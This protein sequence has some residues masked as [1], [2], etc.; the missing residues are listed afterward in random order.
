MAL[1]YVLAKPQVRSQLICSRINARLGGVTSRVDPKNSGLGD[2]IM[3]IGM[4]YQ[5][6]STVGIRFTVRDRMRCDSSG[7]RGSEA[8]NSQLGCLN[9]HRCDKICV[10][11]LSSAADQTGGYRRFGF[12]FLC[13]SLLCLLSCT[14]LMSLQRALDDHTRGYNKGKEH[15]SDFTNFPLRHVI[16][17]RDGVSEGEYEQV[18]NSEVQQIRGVRSC[19]WALVS[20][21]HSTL[22]S[23]QLKKYPKPLKLTYIVSTLR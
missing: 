23:E 9:E 15:R 22:A 6:L 18:R 17:F 20:F 12:S 10:I 7:P 16:V 3:V 19:Y 13:K 14:S 11:C 8:L 5:L 2:D 4:L 21:T 1:K